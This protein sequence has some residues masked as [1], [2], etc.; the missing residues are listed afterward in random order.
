[1]RGSEVETRMAQV[2]DH[3]GTPMNAKWELEIGCERS[4]RG[5]QAVSTAG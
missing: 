2:Q 4:A 1:M 5:L 3:G